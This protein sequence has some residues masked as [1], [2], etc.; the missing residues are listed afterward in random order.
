MPVRCCRLK[1][2]R[3]AC[4][5]SGVG[6]GLQQISCSNKMNIASEVNMPVCPDKDR[7]AHYTT[8]SSNVHQGRIQDFG[9]GGG[10]DKY[11]HNW[12]RVREGECP[13]P[14]QQRGLG[15]R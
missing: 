8:Q 5:T 6:G 10:S 3:L 14:L 2:V 13:F 7:P 11:I 9:K 15:E 12:G 4:E 1:Q